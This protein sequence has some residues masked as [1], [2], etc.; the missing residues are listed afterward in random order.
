MITSNKI[1]TLLTLAVVVIAIVG[2][3]A[4]V[5]QAETTTITGTSGSSDSWNAAINLNNGVP[6]G[7]DDTT[8]N[9]STASG[10]SLFDTIQT[11]KDH[12]TGVVTLTGTEIEACQLEIAN[13]KSRFDESAEVVNAC[14]DL[15]DTYDNTQGFG[16]LFVNTGN[17][18]RNSSANAQSFNW[19]MLKFMQ[20]VF[21]EIYTAQNLALYEAQLDG[22]LFKSS[23]DF[24]GSVKAGAAFVSHT[25]TINASYPK[26]E[27]WLRQGDDL[28]A[29]KPTGTYLAAGTIATVTVGQELVG[30]GYQV[31]VGAHS[32][33]FESKNRP[34]VKR[35]DRC[36]T[37][38]D[39][40]AT[41]IKVANPLGGGIYIEVPYR[42]DGGVVTV[43][44]DNV[45]RSPYFS[46]KSFH[47][48]TLEEWQ[49]IERNYP[50]PW[51]DF[52]T[53]KYMCQVPTNWIYALDDPAPG[54]AD[55]DVAIDTFNDLMG[56]PRDRGKETFYLQLDVINRSSVFAPGYPA[57]N[58]SN[59]NPTT[60]GT[61][62]STSHLIRGPNTNIWISE[63]EFHEQGHAYFFDKFGGEMESTVNLPYVAVMNQTF[64]HDLDYA[65]ATSLGMHGNPHRTLNNTA[66]TWMTV[67]SFSPKEQPMATAEKAYQLKG[68][69]K[70]VDIAK[71]FGW[72]VINDY[73]RQLV[74]EG[75]NKNTSR[76]SDS[77]RI[78]RLSKAAGVDLRPLFHFWGVH[79]SNSFASNALYDAEGLQLSRQIYDRLLEYKALVPADNAAFQVFALNW[80]GRQP[81]ITGNWTEREHAR[82]WDSE[83]IWENQHAPNGEIYVETSCA[84]IKAVM[85]GLIEL[86][87]PD[88]PPAYYVDAGPDM[89]TWNGEPVTLDASIID[90]DG[91]GF[92]G[93]VWSYDPNAVVIDSNSIEDT[94]VTITKDAGEP[95]SVTLELLVDDGVTI[96]VWDTVT[97]EVYD[98]AC[99]ATRLGLEITERTDLNKDCIINLKDLAVIAAKWLYVTGLESPQ[100]K[101][102]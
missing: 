22:F 100:P 98:D 79:P 85:D 83:V 101:Q 73:Y 45:V 43:D 71:L 6:S 41:T 10:D 96:P 68:H 95:I 15:I 18:D 34:P 44:I 14:Q 2:V 77:D 38:F 56:F 60:G 27:G 20:Y 53:D 48:T 84:R 28:P 57:V 1:K 26:T 35:F 75:I 58:T 17:F 24:P 21:D 4:P 63:I 70:F 25:A 5:V 16:P 11:L 91:S 31:R 88:G 12:I 80:W 19:T 64:G 69:A 93:K 62:N 67:F 54:L 74:L 32:W 89:V 94:T 55:W 51:A 87:F 72:Q 33:D 3:M 49:D 82:Q 47:T 65:F 102:P 92:T 97:I 52:Q 39:I 29:R 7:D 30:K 37:L 76:L 61:G 50:A 42:A 99:M 90:I 66:I 86:Y 13:L 23:Q 40:D 9:F 78:F 59:S 81:K 36:T 8:R 46:A